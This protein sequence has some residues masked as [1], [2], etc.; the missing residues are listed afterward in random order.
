MVVRRLM[1]RNAA[2]R[3]VMVTRHP[4]SRRRR[5]HSANNGFSA[6]YETRGTTTL[7]DHA[8]DKVARHLI[9]RDRHSIRPLNYGCS[10]PL[11]SRR[12]VVSMSI[13]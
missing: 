6:P 11:K 1:S 3:K 12:D 4:E 8:L 13:Y 9:S 5:R 10:T 2:G 7:P